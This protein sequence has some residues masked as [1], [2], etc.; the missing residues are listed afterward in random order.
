MTPL[1][2]IA[3]SVAVAAATWLA[4]EALWDRQLFQPGS[5]GRICTNLGNHLAAQKM[6]EEHLL[7][8]DVRSGLEQ[9]T[10]SLEGSIHAPSGS[11]D[12]QSFLKETPKETPVLVY[13]S[14]G[15][16]SRAAV[17]D[18]K[19]EGFEEIYHL[20]RG[21]LGWILRIQR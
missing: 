19:K 7:I 8:L 4:V 1:R 11:L 14:G 6:T 18:L 16:R 5:Q 21:Y 13:C 20:N 10:G 3:V 9:K 2:R 15:F 17:A 12:F